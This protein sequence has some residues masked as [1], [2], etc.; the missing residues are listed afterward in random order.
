M[1]VA[2]AAE[3][4]AAEMRAREVHPEERIGLD[5]DRRWASSDHRHALD[6]DQARDQGTSL[7]SVVRCNQCLRYCC[8]HCKSQ[9]LHTFFMEGTV[10]KTR[11][12]CVNE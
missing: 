1:A 6:I 12:K 3:G 5:K 9:G 10:Q 8:W 4:R 2:A 11:K 7:A